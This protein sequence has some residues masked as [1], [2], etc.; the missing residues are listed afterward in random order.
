MDPT[1]LNPRPDLAAD[2]ELFTPASL[3]LA[4]RLAPARIDRLWLRGSAL[5]LES[6]LI[7]LVGTRNPDGEGLA[8]TRRLAQL[9]AEQSAVVVS[10]GALGI[11]AQAHL[12]ALQHGGRTLVVLPSGLDRPYPLRHRALY[13]RVL[14]EG[15]ALLSMFPKETPPM[16]WTFPKRNE[17]VAALCDVLVLVQAPLSSG[18][19]LTANLARSYGRRVLA[20][21]A[22][23]GDR[24]GAG[25]LALLRAGAQ[26]C[27]TLDDLRDAISQREGPLFAAP[28]TLGV[29]VLSKKPRERA[30]K[31]REPLQDEDDRVRPARDAPSSPLLTPL[32]SVLLKLL[33][34]CALHPDT[35]AE[36]CEHS[37]AATRAALIT[38][39]LLG[40]VRE[41]SDGTFASTP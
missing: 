13:D 19:L 39:T 36:K 33:K 31:L 12:A 18:S 26:V 6:P 41:Q 40:L 14:C 35:L 21:P 8:M 30:P 24:R 28:P 16:S 27:A 38:L 7:A 10:G 2:Q 15:G 23:P 29:R 22:S 25:C 32:Q 37:A 1:Q 5:A 20:V 4:E 11:D 3:G 34:S 9:C 17:L